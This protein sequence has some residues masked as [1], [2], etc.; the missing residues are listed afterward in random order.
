MDAARV[1][2]ELRFVRAI[3]AEAVQ[4]GHTDLTAIADELRRAK[5]SR[6]ALA[7]RVLHELL[8]GA[9]SSPEAELRSLVRSSRRLPPM[10]LNPILV[11]L[12]GTTLPTPDGY[13]VQ[14]GLAIEVDSIAHHL[15]GEDLRRTLNRG[16]VL[17][18][19]GIVVLHFTPTEIRT[20][21]ARVLRMIEASVR[22]RMASPVSVPVK[23]TPR[24]YCQ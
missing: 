21:P 9:R 24:G 1:V 10:L 3:L 18:R 15:D 20:S 11:A 22:E 23:A 12:D 6:T 17:S 4:R 14:A 5:R 16:N 8:D 13:F 2:T 19:Y 7:N